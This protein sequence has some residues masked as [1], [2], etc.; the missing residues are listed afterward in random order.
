MRL[1]K[2]TRREKVMSGLEIKFSTRIV[3][4]VSLSLSLFLARARARDV[5]L[6]YH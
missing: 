2:Y 6:L 5:F 3:G 4:L 1:L